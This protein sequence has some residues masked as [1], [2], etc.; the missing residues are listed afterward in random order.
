MNEIKSANLVHPHVFT[1]Y[2]YFLFVYAWASINIILP[3]LPLW[4]RIFH[5]NQA[6]V[7]LTLSLFLFFFAVT[8]LIWGPLSDKFG[9]RKIILS[10]MAITTLGAFIAIFSVNIDMLIMARVIEAIGIGCGPVLARSIMVDRFEGKA[11]TRIIANSAILVATMPVLATLLGGHILLFGWRFIF[12]VL[13]FFSA[14][15]WFIAF[16]YIPESNKQIEP[17]LKILQVFRSYI[18]CLRNKRYLGAL[19]LY[20]FFYGSMMA[21]YAISAFIFIQHL[22]VSSQMYGVLLIFTVLCYIAGALL[23]R[24]LVQQVKLQFLVKLGIALACLGSVFMMGMAEFF[25]M[26]IVSV[27]LPMMFFIVGSGIMSP[28]VN[29][30]ALSIFDQNKGVASAMLGFSMAGFSAVLSAIMTLF[31]ATTLWPLIGLITS[32]SLVTVLL[33]RLLI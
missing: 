3:A 25:G 27:I 9:R 5:V 29:T 17:Q 1:A 30:I 2:I 28:A 16:Q 13:V 4:V 23:S 6:H 26:T 32:V 20:G 10:G 15:L 33:Y 22:H 21:Y 24:L 18:S 7:S 8:Q 19:L 12:I 14:L 11:I 31:A